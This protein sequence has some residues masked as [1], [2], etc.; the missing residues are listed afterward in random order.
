MLITE[1]PGRLR[2][3]RNGALLPDSVPGVPEVFAEGQGGL[4]E[5]LPHP[6]FIDNKL[7]YLSFARPK[8]EG[9]TTAVIRD[10]PISRMSLK[11]NH[12]GVGTMGDASLGTRTVTCSSRWASGWPA[13]RGT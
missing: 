8:G 10:L 1:R 2:I 5:V 4:F 13:R 3:V 7:L 12:R 11:R 6:N 9:S